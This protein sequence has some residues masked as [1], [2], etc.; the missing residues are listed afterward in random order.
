MSTLGPDPSI[1]TLLFDGIGGVSGVEYENQA[2]TLSSVNLSGAYGMD[3]ATGRFFLFASSV[4]QNVGLHPI[5]GYAIP[6]LSDLGF[7]ACIVPS[8]CAS[9]FLIST[10]ATAQAGALEFQT[11]TIAPPP[12]FSITSL[13]GDYEY[14][15]DEPLD[16]LSVNFSGRAAAIPNGPTVNF[17]QDTSYGDTG[18]CL[19]SNCPL[20]IPFDQVGGA[21]SI[22]GDGSGKFGAQTVSVT[23]GS[24]TFYI[25]ESPLNSHPVVVVVR[26]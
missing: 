18:Y 13:V 15:T 3:A 14:G 22:N 26:E 23:N 12:P 25:D 7:T 16:P 2:G 9:G 8:A 1:G 11:P 5:V 20:L 17:S 6:L 24:T 21:Y 19:V 4:T 10:D